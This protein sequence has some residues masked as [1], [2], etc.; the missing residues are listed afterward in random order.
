MKKLLVLAALFVVAPF[1]A[2]EDKKPAD[3]AKAEKTIAEIVTENKDFS[4]LLAAVKA[5]DLA[6]VLGEG[7]WTVFAPTNKAFEA[8]GKEKLDALLK[9]KETLTAV[10]KSHAVKGTVLAAQA[11]KLDGK[12]VETVSGTKFKITVK[13]TEVMIGNAKVIKTDI[14]AKNGVIHVIDAVL[15]PAAK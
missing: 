9:D 8:V 12:E 6:G 1:A 14:K 4:T 5:A 11:V 2:A 3:T 15:M 10:L 13:D 7:E